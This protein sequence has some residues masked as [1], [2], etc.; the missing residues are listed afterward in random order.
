MGLADSIKIILLLAVV[1]IVIYFLVAQSSSKPI[2]NEGNLQ[3][4]TSIN[5]D[6]LVK[7][8][9][10]VDLIDNDSIGNNTELSQKMVTRDSAR[11]QYKQSSYVNGMRQQGNV[12]NLDTFFDNTN[13]NEITSNDNYNSMDETDGK[14]ASYIPG[15]K[16][17]LRTEDK[18]NNAELLPNEGNS[19]WFED[20][21]TVG[22]KNKHMINIYRP[23]GVNTISTTLKNPSH[24][25]RGAPPNPKKFVSPWNISTIEPD[26]NIRNQGLC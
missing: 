17:T 20:V 18:F 2:H 5:S 1:A 10:N 3:F 9:N 19:D 13:P 24:D 8:S 12:S 26:S 14:Y 7:F 23:V 16:K 21:Q 22:I 4:D 6:K 11:D 15:M 25:L